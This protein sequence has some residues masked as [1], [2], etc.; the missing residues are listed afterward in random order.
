MRPPIAVG[1]Q[2]VDAV[3]GTREESGAAPADTRDVGDAA[4]RLRTAFSD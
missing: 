2:A 3:V 4:T 1:I